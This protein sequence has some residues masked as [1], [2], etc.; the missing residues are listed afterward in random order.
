MGD[1]DWLLLKLLLAAA[2]PPEQLPAPR[3]L[4]LGFRKATLKKS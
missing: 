1:F 3:T 2:S 4:Y